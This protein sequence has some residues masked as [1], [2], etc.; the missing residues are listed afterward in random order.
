MYVRDRSCTPQAS[1]SSLPVTRILLGGGGKE[2]PEL[3]PFAYPAVSF[4]NMTSR[5]VAS[6]HHTQDRRLKTGKKLWVVGTFWLPRPP[7]FRSPLFNGLLRGGAQPYVR[8]PHTNL[9][10]PPSFSCFHTLL[11]VPADSSHS[12]HR[13]SAASYLPGSTICL[14]HQFFLFGGAADPLPHPRSV[15]AI[16]CYLCG[17]GWFVAGATHV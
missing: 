4:P 3:R 9:R 10:P 16:Y 1:P 13:L 17:F 7:K 8:P 6:T 11:C 15:C 5:V 12:Y 2:P 14:P